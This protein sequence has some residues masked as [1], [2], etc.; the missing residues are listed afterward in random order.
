MVY[1]S[2]LAL[3]GQDYFEGQKVIKGHVNHFEPFRK[4]LNASVCAIS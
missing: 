4:I 2:A 1:D 3:S